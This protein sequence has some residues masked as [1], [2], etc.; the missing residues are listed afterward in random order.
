M[1]EPTPAAQAISDH[2]AG[3]IRIANVSGRQ[4]VV[5]VH[6]LWLLPSSWDPWARL[7]ENQGYAVLTPDWP[8]DPRHVD[9]A[10]KHPEVFADKTVG[11]VAAHFGAISA[12]LARKPVVI[13]HSFGGLLAQIL[14]GQGLSGVNTA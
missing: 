13:G 3:Q 1:S 14:A 5:F 9:D 11:Q 7:F 4:P 6:G 2:E 8:D 10:N 12:R